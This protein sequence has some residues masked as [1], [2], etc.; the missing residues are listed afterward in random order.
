MERISQEL[1]F[2]T[3]S[4]PNSKQLNKLSNLSAR[5]AAEFIITPLTQED[6]T[7]FFVKIKS[8]FDHNIALKEV[9]DAELNAILKEF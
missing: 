6:K 2:K 4:L 3:A 1:T 5:Y 9:F 8:Y 7:M